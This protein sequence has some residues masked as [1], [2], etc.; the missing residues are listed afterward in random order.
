MAAASVATEN[1][2]IDI[3]MEGDV[4]FALVKMLCKTKAEE[5]GG[6]DLA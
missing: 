6:R 2:S 5:S 3:S 1:N 4:A